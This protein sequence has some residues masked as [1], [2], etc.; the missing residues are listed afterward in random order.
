M[1][2]LYRTAIRLRRLWSPA[3]ASV[4]WLPTGPEVLS[5]TRPGGFTFLANLSDQPVPVP[6]GDLLLASGPLPDGRVPPD[7]AVWIRAW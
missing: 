2:E 6:A 1:L 7:T 4:E 3:G 5:F